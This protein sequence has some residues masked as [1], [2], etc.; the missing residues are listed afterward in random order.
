MVSGTVPAILSAKE[1]T[2]TI[3]IVFH[4]C[5]R[6]DCER[7]RTRLARPGGNV[8]GLSAF[9]QELI[10][11]RLEL[12]TEAAPA[13][14]RVTVL[15]ER[16]GLG[17]RFVHRP[18]SEHLREVHGR[19]NSHCAILNARTTPYSPSSS[20]NTDSPRPAT[21]NERYQLLRY[22]VPRRAP[23]GLAYMQ[24]VAH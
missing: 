11:K 6:S 12:L 18:I 1:A 5:S 16:S 10:G 19:Q 15:S 3:P 9:A 13:I 23:G 21:H 4:C 20:V 7:A 17:E 8:T 14:S 24:A 2:R 22:S